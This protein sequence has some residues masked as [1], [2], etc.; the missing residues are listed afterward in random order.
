MSSKR[1]TGTAIEILIVIAIVILANLISLSVF[2]RIDLSEGNIYSISESTKAVLRD[3]DDVVN[4]KVYF[5][6]KLP[7]YLTTLTREIRDMIDEYRAYAGADL[8]VDFEDPAADP[9]TEQRVRAL[10]IPPVQLNIIEKDKAE[11]MNAYLGIAIL[12][13]DRKEVIPVVQGAAHLEYE[14]TSAILKVTSEE[15]KTVGILTGDRSLSGDPYEAVRR[16]MQRQYNVTTVSVSGGEMVPPEVNTLVVTRPLGL[17]DWEVFAID[18]FLMRGGRLLFLVDGTTIPDEG[19][20]V[21]VPARTGV[22]SLLAH[23]G[24]RVNSDLVFDRQCGNA[25]FSTGFFRYTV[26][27]M[28]WPM[29]TRTGF[30]DDSP[31]TNQLERV[32]LPWV[33]SIDFAKDPDTFGEIEVL[34]R[35]SEQSWTENERLDLNPQRDFRPTTALGPRNLAVLIGGSFTSYLSG[36]PAPSAGDTSAPWTGERLDTSP[37]T[38]IM[39]I[40]SSRFVQS[41]YLSQYPENGTF[42]LNAV[43]WLTLGESLIGIRSRVVTARPLDEISEG[44]KSSVRFASTF[45]IPILLIAWGLVRRYTRS[46][47]KGG[48]SPAGSGDI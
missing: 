27:Y 44:A 20:L 32:V 46:A 41:D 39:V 21:A 28:L 33:S 36:L 9:E 25:T 13:E 17:G 43:D 34:A 10:G 30:S 14:L 24:L 35:S 12:F 48:I 7:P 29:V 18:Q 4:I 23:Y 42:F 38:R 26:P 5:S 8:I 15:P 47:R 40:G 3:L 6:E 45:A 11:V 1:Q 19:P 16:A 31:V 37:E 2:G 22:D